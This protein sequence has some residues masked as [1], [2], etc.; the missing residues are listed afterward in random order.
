MLKT[1]DLVPVSDKEYVR[2]PA[3]LHWD[4]DNEKP[5]PDDSEESNVT[6]WLDQDEGEEHGALPIEIVVT[7]EGMKE[8]AENRA[9]FK[10]SRRT[11]QGN[12]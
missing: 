6:V 8:I 10:K 3:W 7:A 2:I 5:Y 1:E 11:V 12:S 9:A 4:W